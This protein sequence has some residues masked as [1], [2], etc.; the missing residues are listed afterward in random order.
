M[1]QLPIVILLMY[2]ID[3]NI[4]DDEKFTFTNV[5]NQCNSYLSQFFSMYV[6]H[7]NLQG[8]KKLQHH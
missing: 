5:S 1:L 3:N 4:Q 2:M 7:N 8:S 6:I